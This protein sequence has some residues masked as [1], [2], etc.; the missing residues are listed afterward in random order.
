MR[1]SP[2]S[3]ALHVPAKWSL[4]I[5]CFSHV[6]VTCCHIIV[7]CCHVHL[8][9]LPCLCYL[10]PF[11]CHLLLCHRYFLTCPFFVAMSLLLVAISLSVVAM[12]LLLVRCPS[13]TLLS[14]CG[15]GKG[16]YSFLMCFFLGCLRL[17][18]FLDLNLGRNLSQD[19]CFS[20][21]SLASSLLIIKVCK[22]ESRPAAHCVSVVYTTLGLHCL[23]STSHSTDL[24]SIHYVP[25]SHR[26]KDFPRSRKTDGN[27]GNDS[28]KQNWT[29]D[30]E[31]AFL[32]NFLPNSWLKP[33]ET[34]KKAEDFEDFQGWRH[35]S[36]L[37]VS[38]KFI[39]WPFWCPTLWANQQLRCLTQ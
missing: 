23:V 36:W 39:G 1:S 37:F 11:H 9:L 27:R 30:V 33:A 12:S 10:L 15:G 34:F 26:A 17:L 29:N 8:Y 25:V 16:V 22:M 5:C 2:T 13:L 20:A 18:M 21:G 3:P 35:L 38:W 31:I 6:T 28:L 24:H 14:N 32:L 7:S 4:T 19:S